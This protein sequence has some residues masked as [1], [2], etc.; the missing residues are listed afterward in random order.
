MSFRDGQHENQSWCISMQ[1]E[2]LGEQVS[3]EIGTF[4]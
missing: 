3:V 2:T 1:P 4:G